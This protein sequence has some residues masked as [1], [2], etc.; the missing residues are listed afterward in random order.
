MRACVPLYHRYEAHGRTD[1]EV[2][3]DRVDANGGNVGDGGVELGV[4]FPLTLEV[5]FCIV[6]SLVPLSSHTVTIPST[7]APASRAP[8]ESKSSEVSRAAAVP[9]GQTVA[10]KSAAWNQGLLESPTSRINGISF[11]K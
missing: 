10:K 2:V 11:R 5:T 8:V 9:A 3:P 7:A 6:V 4:G 1:R